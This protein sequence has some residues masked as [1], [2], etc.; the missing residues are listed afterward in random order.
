MLNDKINRDSRPKCG[1][2][3]SVFVSPLR[4]IHVTRTNVPTD[5]V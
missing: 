5:I 3:G 1:E 2:I 4:R